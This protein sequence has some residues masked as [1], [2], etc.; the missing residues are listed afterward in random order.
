MHAFLLKIQD[1]DLL[2][3]R[4][5]WWFKSCRDSKRAQKKGK[6]LKNEFKMKD[7]GKP[8]FCLGLHTDVDTPFCNSHL[9]SHGG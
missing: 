7:L 5:K 3:L 6:L 9:T 1:P 2:L 8:K 4:Y